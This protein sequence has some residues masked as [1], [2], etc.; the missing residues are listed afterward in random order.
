[1]NS[2]QFP[3]HYNFAHDVLGWYTDVPDELSQGQFSNDT[4]FKENRRH[5][6]G[7]VLAFENYFDDNPS[8]KKG[9]F[10]L[11]FWPT[12]PVA[13]PLVSKAFA[14]LSAAMPFA[15]D[16]IVYHPVSQT[17]EDLY[18]QEKKKYSDNAIPVLL[19]DQLFADLASSPLTL[20]EAYG[21]LGIFKPG[22]SNPSEKDIAI[23][24]YIPNDLPHVAGIITEAPQTPLSHI[25]LKARQNNTPNAYLKA[26]SAIPNVALLI[27]QWVHYQVTVSGVK[28]ELATQ[29]E[30]EAWLEQIRPSGQQNPIADLSVTAPAR[31]TTLGF[32]NSI[33]FGVKAANV[34]ELGKILPEGM[35]PN[36]YAIPFALYDQFMQAP[37]CGDGLLEHCSNK[38]HSSSFYQQAEAML[39]EEDF[40]S[41]VDVRAERLKAFRKTIEQGQVPEAIQNSI[42]QI[43]LFWEPN[44]P[45]FTQSLRVRSSTN[46]EDLP[47]FNGAGLYESFTHKE[48]EGLLAESIKQVWAGLWTDR[49]FEERRFYRIN[50]FQTYMGV[51]V[52]PNFGDEQANGVAITKNLFNPLWEGFYVNVQHGEISI[53][54]PEP[55]DTPSG[56]IAAIPDEFLVVSLPNFIHRIIL[57][58]SVHSEN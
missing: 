56:A 29:A 58:N 18:R 5:L 48:D 47:G 21:Q 37:R 33:A 38:E 54:N 30:T 51:L 28:L 57:G 45:P 4:Y 16:R 55:I 36:G 31:L 35:V 41:S 8:A 17:H 39:S 50:H 32:D 20:G 9:V 44:G 15:K 43:R 2:K 24:T 7:S 52:H 46:N 11:E 19:T 12:D 27:D 26:A 23:Y 53:T 25:N 13:Y 34:A 40:Q 22:D 42:E 49:A 14:M 10:T 6:A 1:M 3:W